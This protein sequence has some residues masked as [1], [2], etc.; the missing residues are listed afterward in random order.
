MGRS[1]WL[2][3]SNVKF[4]LQGLQLQDRFAKKITIQTDCGEGSNT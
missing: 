1:A 4:K 3:S 2:E